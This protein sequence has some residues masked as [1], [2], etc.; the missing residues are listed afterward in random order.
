[1][2]AFKLLHVAKYAKKHYIRTD[3]I[4]ADLKLCLQADDYTPGTDSDILGIISTN[5]YPLLITDEHTLSEF[6]KYCAPDKTWEIGYWTKQTPE[7]WLQKFTSDEKQRLP[8]YDYWTAVLYSFMFILRFCDREKLGVE[9][10][11][12][13]RIPELRKK[14]AGEPSHLM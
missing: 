9:K 5:M 7:I 11:P 12:E 3:N 4:W 6:M 1:M 14:H 8:E 2:K 13:S 10:L